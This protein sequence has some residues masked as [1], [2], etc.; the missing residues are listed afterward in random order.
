M[1]LAE[2]KAVIKARL[3][4]IDPVLDTASTLRGTR[5]ESL[6]ETLKAMI[7]QGADDDDYD[8]DPCMNL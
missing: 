7:V 1:A 3:W 8:G 2:H 6:K 4:N 5:T